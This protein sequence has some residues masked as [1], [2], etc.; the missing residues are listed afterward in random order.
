MPVLPS[1][2]NKMFLVNFFFL[3][4]SIGNVFYIIK[5]KCNC[6][7]KQSSMYLI[8]KIKIIYVK[9]NAKK[10]LTLTEV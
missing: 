1:G 10:L 4:T 3:N 2:S 5:K 6:K 9:K 8:K 7:P